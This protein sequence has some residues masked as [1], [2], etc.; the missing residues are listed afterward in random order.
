MRYVLFLCGGMMTFTGC[1]GDLRQRYEPQPGEDSSASAG[2][3]GEGGADP[4][5]SNGSTCVRSAIAP[6]VRITMVSIGKPDELQPCPSWAPVGFEGFT[7][8]TVAPHAC[9][10]CTCA[11]A[12]C[13]LPEAMHVSAAPCADAD[14]AASISFDAPGHGAWEGTCTTENAIAPGQMCEGQLCAQ[15]LTIAAPQIEPCQPV[16]QGKPVLPEPSWGLMARECSIHVDDEGDGC[17]GGESC[18]PAPPEGFVLCQ[19]VA[20]HGYDCPPE[21]PRSFQLHDSVQDDRACGPCACGDA[22]G[23]VC[24]VLVSA[25]SDDTCD[26]V[27]VSVTVAPGQDKCVDLLN[28]TGLGSKRATFVLDTPGACAPSGGEPSGELKPTGP[29]TLCCQPEPDP[30]K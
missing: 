3:G 16:P 2:L 30:A 19:S 12:S 15:S 5:C 1:I 28:G 11:P 6:F 24:A 7:E 18:A 8:L 17:A 21:Y 14:A 25:Y 27:S 10:A 4:A 22:Q 20:G 23:A 9:A 29:M 26:Q 13:A